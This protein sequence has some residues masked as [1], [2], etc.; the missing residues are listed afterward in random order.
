MKFGEHLHQSM[1]PEWAFNYISYDELKKV[2]KA[3]THTQLWT[4]TDEGY[5]VELLER[6]LEKV[7]SFQNVKIGEIQRKLDYY[8]TASQDFKKNGAEE[9][10]WRGIEIELYRLVAEIDVLSKYTRLNYTGFL[11]IVKKH[12]KQTRWMLK[13]IFHVRL[14]SKPFHKE[15]YDAIIVRLSAIYHIVQGRG[16][17]QKGD[18]QFSNQ[19][20]SAFVRD[21]TKYWVHPDNITEV[22]LVIMKHLPVLVFNTKKEYEENDS[23]ISSVYVDN[24]EFECYQG[25]LEKSDMA[26]AIRIRWYGPT[27]TDNGQCFLERKVH[28]EKWTGEQSVKERFPIKTKY[29][30]PY[31]EGTY[32]MDVKFAKLRARGQKSVKDVELMQKLANEVQHSIVGKKMRPSIRAFYRRTAFQ[33]QNDARVRISLDTELALIREDD[34]GGRT[35]AGNHW[36]REDIGIDWPFKQLPAEDIT[37]FPYAVLEV[38]L[39]TH[40]GQEPPGWIVEL[41]NSHLVE[42]CPRFSK[43]IHGVA[44]LLEDKIQILPFWLPQMD[45]DIR[46]PPNTDFGLTSFLPQAWPVGT[47]QIGLRPALPAPAIPTRPRIGGNGDQLVVEGVVGA[48]SLSE[49]E[50]KKPKTMDKATYQQMMAEKAG[51]RPQN[52]ENNFYNQPLAL[53]QSKAS[54]SASHPLAD[55]PAVPQPRLMP[56]PQRPWI[57]GI[58]NRDSRTSLGSEFSMPPQRLTEK[59]QRDDG[60]PS[61]DDL[62]R[63]KSTI[64]RKRFGFKEKRVPAAKRAMAPVRMEPKVFFANERTFLNWLQFTVLLG[65]ISLTLLNFGNYMTRISGAVLTVIT[66]LAMIYAL[67]IFHIR[68]SNILSTKSDRQFHDRYGPT[69]LCV[70]LFGAYF[71]NFYTKFILTPPEEELGTP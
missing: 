47:P 1:Q 20:S 37:R 10:T 44:T 40:H 16:Q 36:K 52:N 39:Q 3:R 26:Q 48:K 49:F 14:N 69:V 23:A 50:P 17:K 56:P 33:L 71:L 58:N 54:V 19:D 9:E 67:G 70:F 41:I 63:K 45:Q 4:E 38:K 22:K 28:R 53:T 59:N 35:R 2:L 57:D 32:T 64:R 8:N 43:Y 31:L 11:K 7:F 24:E 27:P 34:Y 21:T 42:S 68:L 51:R 55:R 30:D 12:D 18:N 66:L 25:R 65:S 46:K 60:D 6:E 5:F 61:N 15:N 13:S 62:L 29:I